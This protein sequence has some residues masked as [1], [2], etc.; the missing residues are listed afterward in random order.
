MFQEENKE[1]CRESTYHLREIY[2]WNQKLY[3]IARNMMFEVSNEMKNILLEV[4][5][6]RKAIILPN[7]QA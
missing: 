5:A 3:Y 2:I 4:E 1:G 6:G 7:K